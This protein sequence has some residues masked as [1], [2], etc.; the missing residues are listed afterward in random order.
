[1]KKS[2]VNVFNKGIAT[3]LDYM[4]RENTQWDFPTINYRIVNK[5]GQGL[6]LTTLPS[7]TGPI[8]AN[9][10]NGEEFRISEGFISI[11]ACEYKGIM[12]IVSCNGTESEIGMFPSFD[13]VNNIWVQT[14]SPL[15]NYTPNLHNH[16]LRSTRFNY[17]T[18][19]M[20]EVL[21]KDSYDKSVDLYICDGVNPNR[22]VNTGITED[23]V[24]TDR[25]YVEND[26]YSELNQ[27]P[28]TGNI[29]KAELDSITPDGELE[30]GNMYFYFRY[31]TEGFD[32]T[33]F[34]G[35]CGVCQ[36]FDGED[37][38][39]YVQGGSQPYKSNKSVN[40]ILSELDTT[41]KY[42]QVAFVRFTS[43]NS[44][45]PIKQVGLYDVYYTIPTEGDMSIRITG[46]ETV[47]PFT[48]AEIIVPK[49]VERTCKTQTQ[50]DNRYWG[51]NWRSPDKN[52]TL[53][54]NLI[55]KIEVGYVI[56]SVKDGS[57]NPSYS[58]INKDISV[59]EMQYKNYYLTY[60][61]VGYF[62]G[63]MYMFV[64]GFEFKD[65]S[66]SSV[67]PTKGWDY[68]KDEPTINTDGDETGIVRFPFHN[69][70]KHYVN[71]ELRIMGAKFIMDEFLDEV[72]DNLT[73]P[74][75]EWFVNN[76]SGIF[77]ARAKR[78]KWLEYQGLSIMGSYGHKFSPTFEAS[79]LY[80][81][82]AILETSI[83]YP[84]LSRITKYPEEDIKYD[85]LFNKK[86]W[87]N[88]D[89]HSLYGLYDADNF[90]A[91]DN[92]WQGGSIM[93]LMMHFLPMMSVKDK[94]GEG[95]AAK[96][97]GYYATRSFPSINKYGVFSPDFMFNI[98]NDD[99]SNHKYIKLVA[100]TYNNTSYIN[101][102]LGWK[103]N[104]TNMRWSY[105]DN[106][107]DNV[108]MYPIF[109]LFYM[110]SLETY[111]D[112][113]WSTA[114]Y[115]FDVDNVRVSQANTK[116]NMCNIAYDNSTNSS[117]MFCSVINEN[118]KIY[119]CNR[120][121]WIKKYIGLDMESANEKYLDPTLLPST[122]AYINGY[123]DPITGIK[124]CDNL[125]LSILNIYN[126]E[127]S[128]VVVSE[129]YPSPTSRL[130]YQMGGSKKINYDINTD[131]ISLEETEYINT[132]TTI[133][134]VYKV[135]YGDCFLQR[136]FFKQ[137]T[138]DASKFSDD[139]GHPINFWYTDSGSDPAPNGTP[140]YTKTSYNELE[141]S[142]K[143]Y[144]RH[145]AIIGIVTENA[146]NTAMR[147]TTDD[148]SY[149]PYYGSYNWAYLPLDGQGIESMRL[150]RG[151]CET[152][153]VSVH[154]FWFKEAPAEVNI[155]PTRIRYSTKHT[156]YSFVDN[157]R[158]F[159]INAYQDYELSNGPIYSLKSYL[160]SIIS[161][162]EKSVNMHNFGR[163][164][165]TAP[166][167][168]GDIILGTSNYLSPYVQ[169]LGNFGTQHQFSVISTENSVYGV[170]LNRRLIWGVGVSGDS[171]GKRSM[172]AQSITSSKVVSKW[173][174]EIANEY[175]NGRSDILNKT[176][177]TPA[178]F[179]GV[180]AGND[181]Y[182]NEVVFSFLNIK[183]TID[184]SKS[185]SNELFD[186]DLPYDY[187][188]ELISDMYSQLA[189]YQN[190]VI[191]NY[192]NR[193]I[194]IS[195]FTTELT[196]Q[197]HPDIEPY[198][199]YLVNVNDIVPKRFALDKR[200][201]DEFVLIYED[202]IDT[203]YSYLFD[204]VKLLWE[205]Y[206]AIM[207]YVDGQKIG[208][209]ILQQISRVINV[210]STPYNHG[211]TLVYSEY[212]QNFT[213]E[214]SYFSHLYQSINDDFYSFNPNTLNRREA[215]LHNRKDDDLVMYNSLSES[216]ISF[217]V[218]GASESENISIFEKL[219][220]NIHIH[221]NNENFSS[222]IF[223]TENHMGIKDPF[224]SLGVEFWSDPE[225]I[226]NKFY[227]PIQCQ[228]EESNNEFIEDSQI[229]GTWLKIT[230]KYTGRIRKFI[231]SVITEFTISEG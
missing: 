65:G 135:F 140:I 99:I 117:E 68:V 211:R 218:N 206:P 203:S 60:D 27:I 83:H 53:L 98:S 155:R 34:V 62:R 113:I 162:Q 161:V 147:F 137:M 213:G 131:T 154:N 164:E 70:E 229:R 71:S 143:P 132:G 90:N 108:N 47:I 156:P 94:G 152:L 78:I 111:K 133:E 85:R 204:E 102:T 44:E 15:R 5:E 16:Y 168:I 189:Y 207:V 79:R 29:L 95:D 139:D 178:L 6:I 200:F 82:Q 222:V 150:N 20:C 191:R 169:K 171:N 146:I 136:T 81:Y 221:T 109:R 124:Y 110:R 230:L 202:D 216:V 55:S 119:N 141:N 89:P 173:I 14:Y 11:G 92:N 38:N 228:T 86:Y 88:P 138:W 201:K 199:D 8:S 159:D 120:N 100:K 96:Y 184:Y 179:S 67:F 118:D 80:T 52:S 114:D 42:I 170:D 49:V 107:P 195:D 188:I 12:Y 54:A 157:Y 2:Q 212:I 116:H 225:W 46:R 224:H 74:E 194:C 187:P 64:A 160:G 153:G 21:A 210:Q 28:S 181:K 76:V 129:W 17:S 125:D 231:K 59:A 115:V 18:S 75:K 19:N 56:N 58:V 7:N 97:W 205:T 105:I 127:E 149:Y 165:V 101:S 36:I 183:Y 91:T 112:N 227:M 128:N 121:M 182:N 32:K 158:I 144:Y 104:N 30:Y 220:D 190:M 9:T 50:E 33:T 208:L 172:M 35:Q 25:V 22:V 87:R 41:Y 72:H 39:R 106:I 130:Y 123:T 43:D 196:P 26:F 1:M 126:A 61:K 151:H 174:D 148:H 209:E 122:D 37:T 192:G 175:N 77:F 180:V 163:E 142:E 23:G 223:E 103:M 51:A 185:V 48:E 66:K 186:Y 145:G 134:Q 214:Y 73:A 215:F 45:V 10:P 31:L 198:L 166:T 13:Q 217:I 4:Y 93:P 69:Q 24:V 167:N 3:D 197:K 177:D 226:E 40:M 219:F 84:Q 63:E 57:D 193:Y 176:I